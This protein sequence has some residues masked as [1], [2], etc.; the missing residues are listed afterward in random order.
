MAP[1][2]RRRLST[3]ALI[4]GFL[5]LFSSTASAASA[6]LGID[7]GTEYIKA[8]LVKPGI[9]LEIVLTKD[10]KRKETA[11]VAFKPLK[12][13]ATSSSSEFP[14]RLYGGDALAL[15]ARF[16]GDVYPNLKPLLSVPFEGSTVVDE[17]KG[18]HPGLRL[19]KQKERGTV[20]FRSQSF[21]EDEEP[22]S[23][24]ELL[25]MELQNIRGNAEVMAGKGSTIRDVVIT[26]PVFYT[27]SEKRAVERAADLA[28]L[29]VLALVSDGLAV[30]LNYATSRTF[31]VVNEGAKPE[32][33][34]IFD[35]G[36]SSTSATVLRFQGKTVKDV[37]KFNKTIQE[38]SVMGTGWDR[39]LG[40]DAL[41]AVI[42]N[43]MIEEFVNS[44]KAKKAGFKQSGVR[45]HGRAAAKLW[46]EAE[47]VRQVLSANTETMAGFE[48]L[49]EDVDFRYKITRGDFEALTSSYA[50]RVAG[51]VQQALDAA[52]VRMSDLDSLI[53]HG[54]AVRTPFVQKQLEKALGD[55]GKIRSN[56]NADEAAV[57]GAAFKGAGISPSFRVKEI[58]AAENAGYAV[59]ASWTVDGKSRQQKLF[60]PTSH[61]GAEKQV[62]FKNLDDF[63]FTLYQQIPGESPSE[64][65]DASVLKVR[66]QNLTASVTHLTETFGCASAD[67]STKFAIR[68]SPDNGLPEVVQGSVS[69]EVEGVEKKGGV[70]DD[71]KGFFGFGGKKGDQQPLK[72][73]PEPADPQPAASAKPSSKAKAKPKKKDTDVP[74]PEVADKVK[75]PKKRT[76]VVHLSFVA[77]AEGLPDFSQAELKRLKERLA[78]FDSSDSSR[79]L[80]EEALN[81]LEA[82]T[83]RSRD[84][85]TEETFKSLSTEDQRAK[86][87]T[88]LHD[89]SEWL[90]G[91]GADAD[92]DTLKSRLKE[93]RGLVDPVLKRKDEALKRPEQIRLL[94][95][96]LNQ[97]KNLI[98]VV[99]DQAEKAA[100][101]SSTSTSASSQTTPA[102]SANDDDFAGLDDEP[103]TTSTASTEPKTPDIP[104]Y[105]PE[106]L[107]EITSV[108]DSIQDWL[109][110]KLA[111]QEKLPE[112]EDP[113]MLAADI[114]SKA[115]QLNKV[116]MDLLQK[117]MRVPPKPKTSSKTKTK[118]KSKSKKVKSTTSAAK[119][120]ATDTDASSDD[121]PVMEFGEG[122]KMWGGGKM[123]SKEEVLEAI[124]LQK[125]KDKEH[126]EL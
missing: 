103:S 79:R 55:G 14:E 69:C 100:A 119:A 20:G 25:A 112:F 56:V 17:Y 96:A 104:T 8:A 105:T 71:V 76:E 99:R 48:G 37:G 41:N 16:P 6:V 15:A 122:G 121:I 108:Y 92:R 64:S 125:A 32:Y 98:T 118:S 84:L 90:Y 24:E 12:S 31:G 106:D 30:G 18:R 54:G 124:E 60:L 7:L 107:T 13:T 83:Y 4:L 67:I 93:L 23:V 11:A 114:D 44:P 63:T 1:P 80:R 46:K 2:G 29:R 116:V 72:E 45:E 62:P 26:I 52:K 95:E 59:G 89:V 53:L 85:L 94:N 109:T 126:D 87:E 36:A 19:V 35:M 57:F 42:V 75:E 33:H 86:I 51:P 61:V 3:V 47:R 49:Y 58:R 113:V 21:G 65:H 102:P 38:V 50:E 40:G 82:F 9:P 68:L 70:V 27:A 39:G 34:L 10:S 22:F 66:T 91:D 73:E 5:F 88:T 120:K 74:D 78:A 101:A 115:K 110:T 97:T 43:N 123:P 117:K 81:T 111:E 28:G 77:E